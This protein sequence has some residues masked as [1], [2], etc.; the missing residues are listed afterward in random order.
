MSF[1]QKWKKKYPKKKIQKNSQKKR[2][3][4]NFALIGNIFKSLNFL[5]K[6]THISPQDEAHSDFYKH[7]QMS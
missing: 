1:R 6:I 5:S 2:N 3:F 4:E 7:L